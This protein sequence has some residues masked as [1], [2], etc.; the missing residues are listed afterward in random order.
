[1]CT[2][3]HTDTAPFMLNRSSTGASPA[4]GQQDGLVDQHIA[5]GAIIAKTKMAGCGRGVALL[6]T[7]AVSTTYAQGNGNNGQGNNGQA[8]NNWWCQWFP[9]VCNNGGNNPNP[10]SLASTPELD[11][12]LLFGIGLSG[13]G[14]YALTRY[15]ARQRP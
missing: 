9:A 4:A 1:M 2:E 12:I 11:S 15:R 6:L 10:P 5:G 14:G 7:T 13:L 8:N 3:D